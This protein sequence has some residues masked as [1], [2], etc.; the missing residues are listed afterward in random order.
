LK[1][2]HTL[3]W[4]Q[5]GKQGVFANPIW[6]N[7]HRSLVKSRF[8]EGEIQLLRVRNDSAVV[9]YLYN[10]VWR[11]HV[12]VLQTG[13]APIKE[14]G[15]MPGYVV[16]AMAIVHNRKQGMLRYDLMHGD[17]LY[18]RILCKQYHKL[19]WVS[20]QRH[21]LRFG[22]ENLVLKVKRSLLSA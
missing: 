17:E 11:R 5:A 3:R 21:R 4:Q 8:P 20:L 16:H 18:K 2:L 13:F 15:M 1:K 7:F 12:Y 6:E 9:G 10:L 14:K 19:Q 22:V